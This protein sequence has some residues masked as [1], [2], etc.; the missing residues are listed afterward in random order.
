[1]FSLTHRKNERTEANESM[2]DKLKSIVRNLDSRT[3]IPATTEDGISRGAFYFSDAFHMKFAYTTDEQE[4]K[5]KE[6]VDDIDQSQ[7]ALENKKDN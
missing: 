4:P 7:G 3:T 1:M 2:M 5:I 6:L